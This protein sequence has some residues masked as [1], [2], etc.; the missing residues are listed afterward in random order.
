MATRNQR[1]KRA[2]AANMERTIELAQ[3]QRSINIAK[4]VKANLSK[5]RERVYDYGLSSAAQVERNAGPSYNANAEMRRTC[6][7]TYK[8]YTAK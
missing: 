5:P 2:K 8:P 1:R 4:I 3:V 7:L 6:G